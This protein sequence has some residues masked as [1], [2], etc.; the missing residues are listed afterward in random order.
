MATDTTSGRLNWASHRSLDEL[1]AILEREGELTLQLPADFHHALF[2]HLGDGGVG[3]EQV[4]V[5]GG[6]ELLQRLGAV[7]EL[8]PLAELPARVADGELQVHVVSPVPTLY[9]RLRR[10]A[11]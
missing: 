8:A 1:A 5:H 2:R 9:L 7:S 10:R 11:E 3:A 4:D 6:P